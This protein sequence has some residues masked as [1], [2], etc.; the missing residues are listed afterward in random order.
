MNGYL[1]STTRS[2]TWES[3]DSGKDKVTS[4]VRGLGFLFG[5]LSTCNGHCKLVQNINLKLLLVLFLFQVSSDVLHVWIP[6]PC[7]YNPS[8]YMFR[9]YSFAVLLPSVCRGKKYSFDVDITFR[10]KMLEIVKIFPY[11]VMCCIWEYPYIPIHSPYVIGLYCQPL[12]FL[13]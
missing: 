8:Y 1:Q 13:S 5:Y 10:W 2:T 12:T 4:V 11:T 9:S 6:L 7:F 3:A